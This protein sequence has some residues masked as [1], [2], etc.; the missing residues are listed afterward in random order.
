MLTQKPLPYV[1]ENT[2]IVDVNWDFAGESTI[3]STHSLHTYLASILV[4]IHH[5]ASRA[6][7]SCWLVSIAAITIRDILIMATP[8][9]VRRA[10]RRARSDCSAASSRRWIW[11]RH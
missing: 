8:I 3:H 6:L 9:K 7:S 10:L 5:S 4:G 2:D 1:E 11:T